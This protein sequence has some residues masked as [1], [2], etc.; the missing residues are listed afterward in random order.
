MWHACPPDQ[1]EPCGWDPGLLNAQLDDDQWEELMCDGAPLNEEWKARM[2]DI[3]VYLQY[4]ED[5]GVE[6]LK[7]QQSFIAM[8]TIISR[9]S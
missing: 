9:M 4:L 6:V 8:F 5:N 7:A 1:G 2:D 3:A